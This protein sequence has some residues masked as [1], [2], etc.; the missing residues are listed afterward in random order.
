MT[1]VLLIDALEVFAKDTLSDLILSTDEETQRAPKVFKYDLPPKKANEEPIYPFVLIRPSKGAGK[2]DKVTIDLF[3][4][5]H[6]EDSEGA[7]DVFNILQ[8][9]VNKLCEVEILDKRFS[10]D[11]GSDVEWEFPAE[12][13]YPQWNAIITTVWNLPSIEVNNYITQGALNG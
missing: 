7:K 5:A 6:A 3:V 13:P 9:L 10:L 1:I 2:S 8:R 4:G 11:S 12:Q